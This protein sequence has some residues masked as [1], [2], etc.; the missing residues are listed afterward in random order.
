VQVSH[1]P[2]ADGELKHSVADITAARTRLGYTPRRTLR[3]VP[4][5]IDAIRASVNA[6][7]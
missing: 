5:V 3:D 7:L 4:A 6:G 1:A 2:A